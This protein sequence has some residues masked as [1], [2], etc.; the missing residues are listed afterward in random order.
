MEQY[1]LS[2]DQGTT[3]SRAILF[4]QKGE[5]VHI[6]QREFKQYFPKPGWVEHNAN[7]IWG[8]VLAVI[9]TVLSETSIKPEQVAA[10][11]IT[12]QRETT[13]VW[14]KHTGLPV[15]NAIVWQS[16]QTADICGWL[17]QQGYDDLFRQKTGL[18]IDPYFSG[19]KVKWILDNVDGAREKAEKGDLLFGTIDTWLIWKLS[20]GRAHVTDY[21]NA[22]RTLMFNI[23]TLQW[24]EEILTILGIP[25]SM[26]PEV[27]PSSEVYAKTIP[28]HFFGVEVPIAGAAGDQQA[29][30]FGQ[31][32][33]EEGMAKNTY[34]TGCFMLMNT[35]EKA[36]QSKHGLLTTIAWGI[37]GKVEYALEGS[38]FVAGSA[39]QWL[40]DG[41]RMI[42][43]AADS[44]T[45]A[46]KVDSTDG[47]YVVPAFV[48]LGTP[49]WD[50]DVRGAV[51][52]LTRGTTKEHFIRATLE[53]LAYQTKD[54]LTAMEADAGI[55]LK[56]LRVDGGAVKNNFLM[57][58]QSDMLG[59]PVERPVI[60]ETTALGSAY[61]AGLAVGYWKDRKE[62]ASQWQLERQ[63][64]P[65]MEKEKQEK[66]YDGWKKAVKAAMAF[67]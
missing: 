50:S 36:V 5:I 14:D 45:Y 3:S 17:K 59:V 30:L 21:S 63:F 65:K 34:G 8:S 58:F 28:H 55:A 20:G 6:A 25:K 49:Y 47:V 62:I 54:V 24:D 35:G 27:R 12:N 23:H 51:F 19:T 10:I 4:N 64:E 39:I 2:L 66:L 56:T 7:E 43:Q 53:S 26:L 13:V 57:Q 11:G 9:A 52:G 15:Y 61:L 31:A 60:N 46:E 67:K 29:A 1:I 44:E 42:K 48:G 40:R 16:R 41:L 22:S 37:D 33:F 18:L 38:I 32:C